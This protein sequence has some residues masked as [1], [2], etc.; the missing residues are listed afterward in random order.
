M[1]ADNN[2]INHDGNN[3][4]LVHLLVTYPAKLII[5][6]RRLIIYLLSDIILIKTDIQD[7]H[8]SFT[9]FECTNLLLYN[10]KGIT[11]KSYIKIV[12]C[13]SY[14]KI[15]VDWHVHFLNVL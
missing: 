15:I 12:P 10:Y 8:F 9:I 1:N 3:I 7:F 14:T 6:I 4:W 2:I 11:S 5:S 13:Q